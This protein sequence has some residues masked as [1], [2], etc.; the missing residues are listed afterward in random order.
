MQ[1]A[2]SMWRPQEAR[3]LRVGNLFRLVTHKWKACLGVA[4][5]N[6]I[7]FA[8]SWIGV[9]GRITSQVLE[10]EKLQQETPF[11]DLLKASGPLSRVGDGKVVR[12]EWRRTSMSDLGCG[13]LQPLSSH[14]CDTVASI[15]VLRLRGPLVPSTFISGPRGDQLSYQKLILHPVRH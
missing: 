5:L 9:L 11:V 13:S 7:C 15:G 1:Q 12:K 3:R 10:E 14:A 4:P 6:Q 8:I 2:V